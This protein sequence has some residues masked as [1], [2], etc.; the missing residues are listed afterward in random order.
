[1]TSS[2]YVVRS[3]DTLSGIASRYGMT[4]AHLA[5]M[6]GI[7]NWNYIYIGERLRVS[8]A[9]HVYTV[10]SGDTLSGIAARFGTTVSALVAKNGINNANLI[11]VGE[12]LSY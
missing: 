4:T 12:T 6:N 1:M 10:Q 2:I 7:S 3:G 11:F 8:G 5:N 9:S